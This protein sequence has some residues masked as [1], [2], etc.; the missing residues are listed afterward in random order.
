MSKQL[1]VVAWRTRYIAEPGMI[2]SYPWAYVEQGRRLGYRPQYETESLV[3]Q[4]EALAI[5]EEQAREVERL[6]ESLRQAD[7]VLR[8]IEEQDPV[9]NML[10]PQWA[11]RIAKSA[12]SALTASQGD[13]HG[14]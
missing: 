5:I 1:E 13:Q 6:T 8:V 2:G 3:R 10:D 7:S 4:S 14:E 12:R 11:A 9:E